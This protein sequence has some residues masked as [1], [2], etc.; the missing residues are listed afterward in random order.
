MTNHKDR[1][2]ANVHMYFLLD[3]SDVPAANS[4]IISKEAILCMNEEWLQLF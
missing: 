3:H 4:N 2:S 1:P